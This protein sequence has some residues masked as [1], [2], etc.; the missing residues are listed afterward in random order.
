MESQFRQP[1][2][3]IN[4]EV[5]KQSIARVFDVLYC[6]VGLRLKSTVLKRGP[7]STP[8]PA[9]APVRVRVRGRWRALAR[10]CSRA[11]RVYRIV[12]ACLLVSGLGT[13]PQFYPRFAQLAL[14]SLRS[15]FGGGCPRSL[16]S[17]AVVCVR[18]GL[19]SSLWCFLRF[20]CSLLSVGLFVLSLSL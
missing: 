10:Y 13:L 17:C 16:S 7:P 2:R 5:N 12:R 11:R 1:K 15:A 14:R 9:R 18:G 20:L 19:L 8:P 3:V 4:V 6:S